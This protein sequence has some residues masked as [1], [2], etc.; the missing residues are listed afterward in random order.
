TESQGHQSSLPPI[1]E[2]GIGALVLVVVGGI[3]MSA[4]YPGR[5]SLLL[6]TIL[7]LCSGLMVISNIISLA[8]SKALARGIFFKVDKWAL[9]A[10]VVVAGMLEYVFTFDGTHD[11]ALLLLSSMLLIFAV[12]I[13]IIIAFTVAR[14]A[15]TSGANS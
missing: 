9:L 7:A 6:P 12:N 13:P 4:Y 2:I 14:Y 8:R 5:A 3:Y 10:Y 11:K 1:T 15:D